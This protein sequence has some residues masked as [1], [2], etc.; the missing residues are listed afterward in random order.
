MSS[1]FLVATTQERLPLLQDQLIADNVLLR[2]L[3]EAGRIKFGMGGD[4]FSFRVRKSASGIVKAVGDNSV[5]QARTTNNFQ[6]IT[7][8]YAAYAAPLMISRLQK[9]RN[10]GASQFAKL[11]ALW[12]QQLN[13]FYQDFE[14]RIASDL[15]DDGNGETGDESSALDG[16][17]EIMGTTN[18]YLSI[19]RTTAANSWWRSHTRA[20]PNDALDDDDADGITN[21]MQYL[22]L[23]HQDACVSVV[24]ENGIERSL[25]SKKNKPDLI[26]CGATSFNN[27]RLS[28]LPQW[29][30]SGKSA[31]PGAELMFM[32]AP[33]EWDTFAVADKIKILTLQYLQVLVVGSTMI[34]VDFE[35]DLSPSGA[36]RAHAIDLVSQLQQ[37]SHRPTA[38][39]EL[40]NT[41]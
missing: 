10:E 38:L 11:F 9:K 12:E 2:R 37:F 1:D 35:G 40:T 5:A 24:K 31:D 22:F 36:P 28:L 19:N 18:T 20:V 16:L 8:N 26:Y 32:G 41:D 13:E 21:I 25:G 14:E 15:T 29:Q 23:A 33:I 4:G 3:K 17:D 7:G 34:Y 39:A 27:I 6:E 30:Y